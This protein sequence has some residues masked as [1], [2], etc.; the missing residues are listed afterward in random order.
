MSALAAMPGVASQL[1]AH[2]SMGMNTG[3]T[4]SE[5]REAF[6]L[7]ETNISR[8]Q[9]EAARKSLAKVVAARANNR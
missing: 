1:E 8:Q 4:E 9:A 2:L 7:I 5:L 3:L 6:G